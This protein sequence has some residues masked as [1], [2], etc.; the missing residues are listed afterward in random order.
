M[1]TNPKLELFKF[2]NR[3]SLNIL[4]KLDA[5]SLKS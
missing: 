5:L 1:A 2:S 3:L 4:E